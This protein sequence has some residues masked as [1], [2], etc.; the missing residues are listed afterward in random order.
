MALTNKQIK[1]LRLQLE[2]QRKRSKS[3]QYIKPNKSIEAAYAKALLSVVKKCESIANKAL[4]EVKPMFLDSPLS[5]F[6]SMLHLKNQMLD[7]EK[8]SLEATRKFTDS[9]NKFHRKAFVNEL[10]RKMGIDVNNI[11]TDKKIKKQIDICIR[12]NVELIKTI[13]KDYFNEIESIVR[14]GIDEKSTFHSIREE[15]LRING[16]NEYRARLIA[17]D[18][19]AKFNLQLNQARQEDLG[20]EEYMWSTSQDERVRPSHA[21]KEGKIFKWANPPL[22]TGHPGEDV[23]CRCEAIPVIKG[24]EN[25]IGSV[26]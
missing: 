1:L 6:T 5:S 11:L 20:I 24:F 16:K 9:S 17:R 23:Q 25:I 4:L 12:R 15:L 10:N 21:A 2:K 18:Q 14:K 3:V 7:L 13:P 26:Q 19:T 22:D 8:F